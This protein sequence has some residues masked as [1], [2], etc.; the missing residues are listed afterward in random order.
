MMMM[1]MMMM[2]WPAAE[3]VS[4]GVCNVSRTQSQQH[5]SHSDSARLGCQV[6]DDVTATSSVRESAPQ[7]CTAASGH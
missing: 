7:Q 1:M 6:H 2:C 5:W 3:T 4:S